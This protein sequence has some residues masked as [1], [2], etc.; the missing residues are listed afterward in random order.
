M[1][2][3]MS[4]GKLMSAGG[5]GGARDPAGGSALSA[6]APGTHESILWEARL[7]SIRE[8]ACSG[9]KSAQRFV[10][11]FSIGALLFC[12]LVLFQSVGLL[13][14]APVFSNTI[15][16]FDVLTFIFEF[17]LP[18][19][20]VIYLI[21]KLVETPKV[22]PKTYTRY[23]DQFAQQWSSRVFIDEELLHQL[24][25]RLDQATLLNRGAIHKTRQFEQQL[26]YCAS[27]IESLKRLE[28]NP[29]A[30]LY[31][32]DISRAGTVLRVQG[33]LKSTGAGAIGIG[34]IAVYI[35]GPL[36]IL[37]ILYIA[38]AAEPYIAS[39]AVITALVDYILE[40]SEIM[41]SDH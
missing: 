8:R 20:I 24:Q 34:C 35:F 16:I 41:P 32:K 7:M 14:M 23:R 18:L 12:G 4:D 36:A 28:R 21:I 1:Q 3:P 29:E 39:R 33:L 26:E 37:L 6:I 9:V 31:R 10:R 5:V 13:G 19:G 30:R 40:R 27:H 22:Y 15:S 11:Y 17:G 25:V 2:S 38:Y